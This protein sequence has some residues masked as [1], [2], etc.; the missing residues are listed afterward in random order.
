LPRTPSF[1]RPASPVLRAPVP[2]LV[3]SPQP[4]TPSHTV[5]RGLL[6]WA[7]FYIAAVR[8]SRDHF[9]PP[10]PQ[11]FLAAEPSTGRVIVIAPTRAAPDTIEQALALEPDTLLEREHGDGI[12]RLAGSGHRFGTTAA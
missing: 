6:F 8:I 12:R 9:L 5:E 3:G 10:D 2:A 11:A 1:R 7:V 4:L